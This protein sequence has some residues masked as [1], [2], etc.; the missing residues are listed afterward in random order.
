[1][2][3]A[4]IIAALELA[5]HPEGGWFRQT[6]LAEGPGRPAGSAI[7]FLLQAGEVS[8][9]HRFDAPEIWHFHA[10]AALE[11]RIAPSDQGPV[12]RLTL[13]L[14]LGAGQRPQQLV[15]ADWWQTARPLGDWT[16]VG[17]TVTPAFVFETFELAPKAFDIEVW[18]DDPRRGSAPDPGIF[19]AS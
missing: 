13:G 6:W 2:D 9:W 4:T 11:L 8:H 18:A 14:D 17:C 7:Y 5:P 15:P 16:L 12:K 10:G 1:M 19:A 3:A